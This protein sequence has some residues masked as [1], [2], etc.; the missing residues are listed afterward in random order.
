[1]TIPPVGRKRANEQ[2]AAMNSRTV[3]GRLRRDCR[4][5]ANRT[6]VIILAVVGSIGILAILACAGCGLWAFKALSTDLPPA[7]EA[8]EAF[9]DD[10]KSDRIKAAYAKTST[11]FQNAQTFER[12]GDYVDKFPTLKAHSSRTLDG[13]RVFQGTGGMQATIKM[14]L[15]SANKATPCILTMVPEDGQ[16]KVQYLN[17][18]P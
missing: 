11:G 1:L 5:T 18:Q 16:W 15:H 10:L 3:G 9:L 17:I 7:R 8:A 2:A 13:G 12:F 4:G 6:L 14:T